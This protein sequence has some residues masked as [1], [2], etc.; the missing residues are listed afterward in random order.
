MT[1]D[2]ESF[3][4]RRLY[5]RIRDCWNRPI[6]GCPSRTLQLLDR[7]SEDWNRSFKF[8]GTVSEALNFS[9]YNYLGFAQTGGPCADAV[10]VAI[11]A[12]GVGAGLGGV[13]SECATMQSHIE[14]EAL[15]ARFVGKEA[16]M[17]ISMGF[18]T[19][20]TTLP[21]LV[22]RGCLIVSDELNHSSLV[23][24]ARL[25]GASIRIFKHNNTVDLES[26]LRQAIAEGQPRS[27]RPWK[28]ILVVVEGLYSMEG[29]ICHL[30]EIVALKKKYQFY[31]Y[32]DEAHSIGAL[33]NRGGGV[34]DFLGKYAAPMRTIT[35][36]FRRGPC[37]C[38]YFDG[39][40]Y[41]EFWSCRWIYCSFT[42]NYQSFAPE[43][44]W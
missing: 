17:V 28:K 11:K 20:S 26:V 27:H 8:T 14:L 12:E 18:A 1:S 10:S 32:V 38:R 40:F 9:S 34:C 25:S 35:N 29:S 19:N 4:T 30:P 24:G 21:A 15:V 44:S 22:E 31:L 7:H 23:F 3:Y 39:N 37:R 41:K 13:R 2:F 6:T 42:A 33:G 36:V 43:I 5:T 16:S